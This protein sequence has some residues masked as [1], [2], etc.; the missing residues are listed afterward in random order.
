MVRVPEA[1]RPRGGHRNLVVFTAYTWPQTRLQ[2]PG[3]V[4][5]PAEHGY[6]SV[7]S[8]LS[9]S[10]RG[11]GLL[12]GPGGTCGDWLPSLVDTR[13][14]GVRGS[15]PRVGFRLAGVFDGCAAFIG[16]MPEHQT[17]TSEHLRLVSLGF[18][19]GSRVTSRNR[20]RGLWLSKDVSTDAPRG[21][22]TRRAGPTSRGR[23]TIPL[24]STP[25]TGC[26]GLEAKAIRE[27]SKHLKRPGGCG[28][29]REALARVNMH[30][31]G[32]RPP[33]ALG[34]LPGPP[35]GKFVGGLEVAQEA[36]AA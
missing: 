13:N 9:S 27:L 31:V 23:Q 36:R 15:N 8:S 10:V 34:P 30:E 7:G 17:N 35:L 28:L 1:P 5:T 32:H 16:N 11:F 25:R 24:A 21:I 14:E 12:R 20:E 29:N 3:L 33:E 18:R 2:T 4:R 19:A 26:A 6:A 22:A